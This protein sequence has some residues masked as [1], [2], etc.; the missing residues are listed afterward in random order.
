LGDLLTAALAISLAPELP[1]P[2]ARKTYA[3]SIWLLQFQRLPAEV[4]LP[5]RDRIAYA[6][7]RGIEGE[8]GKEGKKGSTSDG[9]KAIHDL[10][11]CYPSIFVPAF[12]DLLPSIFA[13]LL[14]PTLVLRT[15]ACHALGGYAYGL[16]SLPSSAIHTHAANYTATYLT[17]APLGTPSKKP[18]SP[19][20]DPAIIRTLRT[21][22]G[23]TEPKHVAQGPVWALSLLACFIVMLGPQ[24]YLDERM[25]KCITALSALATRHSRS[26]VRSLACLVWRSMTWAYFRPIPVKL[27]VHDDAAGDESQDTAEDS[28]GEEYSEVELQLFRRRITQGWKILSSMTDMGAAVST[29]GALFTAECPSDNE[30]RLRWGLSLLTELSKRGGYSCQEALWTVGQLVSRFSP[31]A[32]EDPVEYDLSKLLPLGLFSANPG[33]LTTEYTALAPVVKGLIKEC[34]HIDEVRVLTEEEIVTGWVY[35]CL[36]QVWSEGLRA[37]KMSWGEPFPVC[38][39]NMYCNG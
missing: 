7:R 18:S 6:L 37:L 5:A 14:A 36:M 19:T 17:K 8:L 13:Q 1:T 26:S 32:P 24:V 21:T 28:E 4:L 3:L 38:C 29:I 25:S 31:N 11:I 23:A 16:A 27:S 30:R 9:L 22:L 33:L 35:D 15:Q 2:N 10:S 39:A 20:K 34:P 12:T